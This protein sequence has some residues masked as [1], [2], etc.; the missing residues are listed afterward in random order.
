MNF[1]RT[2]KAVFSN[3]CILIAAFNRKQFDKLPPMHRAYF[4]WLVGTKLKKNIRA[5]AFGITS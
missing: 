5:G 3:S 2:Q 1:N 4:D